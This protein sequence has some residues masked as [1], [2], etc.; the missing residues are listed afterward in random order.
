MILA[1]KRPS[2]PRE[3]GRVKALARWHGIVVPAAAAERRR[4]THVDYLVA[5]YSVRTGRVRDVARLPGV[6]A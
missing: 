1:R 5:E 2:T 4:G 3:F 6:F